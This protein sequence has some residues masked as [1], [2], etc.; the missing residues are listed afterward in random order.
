ML[1]T[2]AEV[3]AYLKIPTQVTEEDAMLQH[4]IQAAQSETELVRDRILEQPGSPITETIISKGEDILL[5]AYPVE[6]ISSVKVDGVETTNYTLRPATGILSGSFPAGAEVEVTY[7]GGFTTTT[8]PA[9][10]KQELLERVAWRYENRR[11][12]R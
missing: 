5:Q 6:S 4:F 10:L 3:K 1:L 11:G 8:L 12:T 2:I 9:H 7:I